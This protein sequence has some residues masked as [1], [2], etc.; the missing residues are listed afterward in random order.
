MRVVIRKRK[1]GKGADRLVLDIHHQGRR[2]RITLPTTN[3][4]EARRMA[5]EVQ[6][7]LLASGWG[8]AVHAGT[9]LDEFAKEY[10]GHS[11][12]TK[13]WKTYEADRNALRRLRETVGNIPM[14]SLT[15]GHLE[16]F[17][18]NELKRVKPTSLNIYLRH[19]KSALA[20][21]VR[22]GYIEKNPAT[23]LPLCRVPQ[24]NI[25]RYLS[26]S[27][28]ERL[29]TAAAGHPDLLRMIDFCLRTGA[30]RGELVSVRWMDVDLE[31]GLVY[32]RNQPNF[33]TKSK[34]GRA[35]PI[36]KR[37]RQMLEE[38]RPAHPDPEAKLFEKGYWA[39]GSGF[40]AVV[41]QA[42]LPASITPH[43]LRHTFCSFL[44]MAGVPMA[45]V[46][47]LMGHADISTS[48]IYTHL[49]GQ[50]KS[51]SVENLPF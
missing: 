48:M 47:E 51:E 37:L 6:R 32:I 25:P 21:A 10:V 14:N 49:S 16:Q 13:A 15:T 41:K 2:K 29:R 28:V 50:H 38:M 45:T 7:Q 39:F 40:R 19:I 18:L 44:V 17:R 8:S 33:T 5:D 43:V 12:S 11:S 27:E 35:I 4:A 34:R 26:S 22:N 23:G 3:M 1:G 31:R 42:G 36:S 20:F 46:K 30:R 9:T 24:N